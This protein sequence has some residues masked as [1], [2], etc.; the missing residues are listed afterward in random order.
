MAEDIVVIGAG[1]FGRETLDVLEAINGASR[2][3]VWNIVGVVDD[4]PAPI[5]QQRLEARGVPLLG[6]GDALRS[7]LRTTQYVIGIGAPSARARLSAK[8]DGWGGRAA[9]LIHPTAVIGTQTSIGRGAVICGGVQLST[10][11]RLGQHVHLNPGAIIGHDA[12][13]DDFVSVNPGAIVSGEAHVRSRALIGAGAVLLQGLDVGAEAVVGASACVTRDVL[14][15]TT[16][17][18][19]PAR[20]FADGVLL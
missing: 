3:P 19:V 9:T 12:I 15:G 7:L 2:E 4:A 8:A 14:A 17:K 18:G 11:A 6:G 16:V 1:G 20:S 10:N 13:L 5:Q